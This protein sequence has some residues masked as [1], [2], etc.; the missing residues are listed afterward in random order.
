MISRAAFKAATE[1]QSQGPSGAECPHHDYATR[2]VDLAIQSRLPT[3][4][5]QGVFVESGGLMSYCTE[6][7]RL[8][9]TRGCL[10]GQD[11]ERGQA[12]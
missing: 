9:Q 7:C 10:R 2:I 4:F 8:R 5:A 3:M 6:S 1:R 11:P 12:R